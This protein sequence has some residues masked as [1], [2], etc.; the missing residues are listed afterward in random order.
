ML[1]LL[2]KIFSGQSFNVDGTSRHNIFEI[3]PK[4]V[5]SDW[6]QNTNPGLK[7]IHPSDS[8][9]LSCGTSYRNAILDFFDTTNSMEFR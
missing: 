3:F 5:L 9:A 4:N 7:K 8:L 2:Y 6:L 1:K